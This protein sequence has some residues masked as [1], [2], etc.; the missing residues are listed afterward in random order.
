MKP[1]GTVITLVVGCLLVSSAASLAQQ[2]LGPLTPRERRA[3]HA[4]LTS[5]WIANFCGGHAWGIGASYDFTYSA[6]VFADRGHSNA[7]AG[8]PGFNSEE[9]CWRWVRGLLR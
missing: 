3:Y 2:P 9:Y 8:A 6:C 5:T 1:R 4:C 7:L